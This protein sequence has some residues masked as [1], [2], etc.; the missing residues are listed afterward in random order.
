MTKNT[1]TNIRNTRG[2]NSKAKYASYKAYD[3]LVAYISAPRDADNLT[4]LRTTAQNA[5]AEAVRAYDWQLS[6]N[7]QDFDKVLALLLRRVKGDI[8]LGGIAQFRKFLRELG[9]I[10]TAPVEYKDYAAAKAPK[11]PKVDK[12]AELRAI[13]QKMADL[14]E[15]QGRAEID[16]DTA[17][18]MRRE[19]I[20]QLNE[21][22]A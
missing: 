4:D 14:E 13:Y 20:R 3:A 1:N 7:Q 18:E 12:K 10:A 8:K 15:R 21:L 6:V 22:A 11:A 19:L 9:D 5:F 2:G 16:L 17:A